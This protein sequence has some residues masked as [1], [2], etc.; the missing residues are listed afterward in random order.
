MTILA[1]GIS[2][3]ANKRHIMGNMSSDSFVYNAGNEINTYEKVELILYFATD[4]GKEL[5][6]VYRSVVYN[7]NILMVRLAIEQLLSGPNTDFA[8]PTLN[9]QTKINSVSVRDGVCYVDFDKNFLMQPNTVSAE[10]AIYSLVNTVCAISD[11]NKVQISVNGSTDVMFMESISLSTVF[12]R[13][14]DIVSD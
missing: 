6:P 13:N 10:A 7:S 12:E 3:V 14:L 8:Y 4:D 1:S 9:P 5:M 2:D 11:V